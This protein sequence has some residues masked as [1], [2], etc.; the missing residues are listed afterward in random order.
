[1]NNNTSGTYHAPYFDPTVDELETL[2]QLEI[3]RA[4]SVPEALRHH[5]SGRLYERGYVAKNASGDLAITDSGRA[6]IR[7]QDA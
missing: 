4:I 2:K 7:R 6:V 5:L 3:G 1:M